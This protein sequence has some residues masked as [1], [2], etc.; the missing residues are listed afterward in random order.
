[1][2]AN[3]KEIKQTNKTALEERGINF[4][5]GVP[6]TSSV[7]LKETIVV[8]FGDGTLRFFEKDLNPRVVK[9]HKG[10]VLCMATNGDSIFTGGDDGKFL[11]VSLMGDIQEIKNFKTRWVDCVA[12]YKLSLIHI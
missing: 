5:I 11:K 10:V 12:A 7:S 4:D 1:M 2:I 9:A 3:Q 8:G 6:V